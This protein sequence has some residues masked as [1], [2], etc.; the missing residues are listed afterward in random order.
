[1]ADIIAIAKFPW[2]KDVTIRKI[3]KAEIVK[4]R[5]IAK[6]I[7]AAS[8]RLVLFIVFLL[9]RLEMLN[10]SLADSIGSHKI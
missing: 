3:Q 7:K 5:I 8:I 10:Q 6:T 9:A 2:I 1:M 4:D